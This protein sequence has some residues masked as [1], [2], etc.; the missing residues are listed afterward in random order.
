MTS[1]DAAIDYLSLGLGN[2]PT[3]PGS[4]SS[5]T[6]NVSGG[7]LTF[8]SALQVGDFGGTG[9]V[10]QTAGNV[11]FGMPGTP[12]SLNIG[13]QGGTG[14]FNVANGTLFIG[15]NVTSTGS[16][17]TGTINQTGGTLAIGSASRLF[18]AAAG[19]GTY[20][21][22]GGTPQI[23]GSSLFGDFNNLGGTYAF[24]LGGGTIQVVGSALS[25]GVNATL[26][27]GTTST[28]DTNGMGATWSGVL[29]GSGAL[30]KAGNG[31]LTLSGQNT[32]T[33]PTNVRNGVLNLTGSLQSPV[34]V[35]ANGTLG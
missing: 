32:F 20:N 8:N 27:G 31:V 2:A 34:D 7:T 30:A 19:N 17:G 6:L 29:S 35:E 5:G 14:T 28:I 3:L 9:T 26:V 25:A 11:V 4:T 21:L 16:Q 18:L 22:S 12:V 33:G 10:T 15:S 23:G 1:S 24:N 13:N